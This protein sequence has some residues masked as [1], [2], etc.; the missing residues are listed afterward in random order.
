VSES[1]NERHDPIPEPEAAADELVDTVLAGRYRILHKLGEGAMGAVY[2]GEHLKI[3]RRD[4]IK[5]LRDALATDTEAMAR[6]NRGARN[7]AAIRHPNVCTIYDYGDAGNGIQ[8]LA[9][10]YIPGESLKDVLDRVGRLPLPHAVGI[11]RQVA[12]ALQA[13]HDAGIVHRDLK[14]GNIMITPGRDETDTVRVVDFDLAK[15]ETADAA[16]VTRFGFVVG[17]P[18]YMSPEQLTGDRLDA[19]SDVYSLALVLIRM[20]TGRLP[21]EA[22]TTQELIVKRLTESPLRL[23]QLGVSGNVPEALQAALDRA[24]ERTAAARTPSAAQFA[25]EV[26]AALA[27]NNAADVSW[28]PTAGP[29]GVEQTVPSTRLSPAMPSG[30]PAVQAAPT[31]APPPRAAVSSARR[32]APLAAAAGGVATVA[33]LAFALIP[34]G[35]GGVALDDTGTVE[36][37][38]A[39]TSLFPE[40]VPEPTRPEPEPGPSEPGRTAAQAATGGSPEPRAPQPTSSPPPPLPPAEAASSVLNR[41]AGRL[42]PPLPPR[43]ALV[44]I[45]DSAQAV[46]NRGGVSA[47]DRAEAAFVTGLAM[48]ATD[49]FGGCALWM[50]R[51]LELRPDHSAARFTLSQCEP[52]TDYEY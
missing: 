32:W 2:L 41:L 5:V 46:W 44:A 1:G 26:D 4:A 11:I 17:T 40:S 20:L 6:F 39:G 49:N 33:I 30:A 50:R 21:I 8:F 13:A 22:Q 10:E 47:T 34:R 14:P 15:N 28:A 18:E 31:T 25:Q 29:A 38:G 23:D 7:V 52:E 51:A 37:L 35:G 42:V 45:R 9:M 16:E 48:Q 27:A 12:A 24:L 3:G 19:R 43:A 36:L